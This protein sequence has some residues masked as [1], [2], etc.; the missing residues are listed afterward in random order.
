MKLLL[1]TH[2]L[3]WWIQDGEQLSNRAR[4]AIADGGNQVLVS[5]ASVWEIAIKHRLGKLSIECEDL[6]S[7]VGE[8]ITLNGFEILEVSLSNA[9]FVA[10]LPLHHQDPFDHL[11]IAQAQVEQATLISKDGLF[12][13]YDVPVLW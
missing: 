3:L 8:Q 7:F 1:D 9:A 12:S 4:V 6:A 10:E 2:A 13:Q 11:L 5:A